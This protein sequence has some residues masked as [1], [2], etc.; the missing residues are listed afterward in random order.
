VA[1]TYDEGIYINKGIALIGI[2]TPTIDPPLD[3]NVVTFDGD[4]ADNGTIFGFRITGATNGSG[5]YCRN[6]ADPFITNNTITGNYYYGIRCDYSSPTITNNTITG[7]SYIGIYCHYSSP[8]INHNTISGNGNIGIYCHYSSPTINHNTISGNGNIGIYCDSSSPTITNNTISGNSQH[9]IS[10]NSSSSPK[11]YNNI[12]TENGTTSEDDWGIYNDGSGNPIINYNCVFGN[13]L[14]SSNNYFGCSAGT[15]DIQEDP[16]F[17]GG[18]DYHLGS[19]SPCIDAG[20]NTAPGIPSTDKDGNPRIIN[21]IVDMGAYEFQ[22]TPTSFTGT[23]TIISTPSCAEIYIDEVKMAQA[24][25]ATLTY[26]LAGTHNVTLSL[27]GYYKWADVV[28]IISS[29]TT[30]LEVTLTPSAALNLTNVICYPNPC[31]GYDRVTFKN[32]TDKCRIKIY[33]IAAE[34]IYEKELTNTNGSAEWN[35]K[36]VAS[37]V[38]IY[39]ITNNQNQ[40]ATG[41]IGLIR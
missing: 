3:G 13:G 37:G 33:N 6:G 39:L 31:K 9:G 19:I 4:G 25:P 29:E 12:I 11:I 27:Y 22:G 26:I 36:D 35:C 32:L 40:K 34:R 16:Q 1:G 23:L 14:G 15:N 30:K 2:G 21:G 18:G 5:I 24:T 10:C 28:T 7:N 38:Y 17:I 8:T 41:K 20:T